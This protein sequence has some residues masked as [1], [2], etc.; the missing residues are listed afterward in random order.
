MPR[1]LREE[2]EQREPTSLECGDFRANGSWNPAIEAINRGL[3]YRF[4]RSLFR[5]RRTAKLSPA[6]IAE[7]IEASEFA[8]MF[9]EIVNWRTL[10]SWLEW[11]LAFTRTV[12]DEAVKRAG[13]GQLDPSHWE[14]GAFL[15][16]EDER[17]IPAPDPDAMRTFIAGLSGSIGTSDHSERRLTDEEWFEKNWSP[18]ASRLQPGEKSLA[19]TETSG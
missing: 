4:V 17:A 13:F 15:P 6:Q 12:A 10:A 2:Q 1:P 19:E 14:G 18:V 5:A 8:P 3:R 7:Q 11:S 16:G 9:G